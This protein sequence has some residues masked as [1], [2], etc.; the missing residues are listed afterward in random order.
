MLWKPGNDPL[1][2]RMV[3]F[4]FGELTAFVPFSTFLLFSGSSSYVSIAPVLSNYPRF[5]FSRFPAPLTLSSAPRYP[6]N[7]NIFLSLALHSDY[8][9][10]F[11]PLHPRQRRRRKAHPGS[12]FLF[13]ARL[14]PS[15]HFIFGL[16]FIAKVFH[17]QNFMLTPPLSS[18][19]TVCSV[20]GW[21][22]EGIKV[23]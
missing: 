9:K 20:H 2:V 13:D 14:T 11:W 15:A 6:L 7:Y 5:H 12:R 17:N 8:S 21:T 4:A 19:S 18:A 16:N 23:T 22:G 3:A 10:L 1:H